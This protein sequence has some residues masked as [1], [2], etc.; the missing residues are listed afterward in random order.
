MTAIRRSPELARCLRSTGTLALAACRR[1]PTGATAVL[2]SEVCGAPSRARQID[3]QE[4]FYTVRVR[5]V[6]K[7]P[8]RTSAKPRAGGDSTVPGKSAKPRTGADST[9]PGKPQT[10]VGADPPYGKACKTTRRRRLHGT[11]KVA[12]SPKK[13]AAARAKAVTRPKP[14]TK[15]KA[16]AKPRAAVKR[17]RPASGG[18][19]QP[20]SAPAAGP[21]DI[22]MVASEMHPFASSGGLAD[23]V[24][25][26]QSTLG[27]LGHTV[28]VIVPRYRRVQVSPGIAVDN[29]TPH[30]SQPDP[31]ATATFEMGER[32]QTVS[33]YRRALT[34]QLT[35]VFVDVPE[36]FDRDGLYGDDQGDYPD[37]A[38]RFAAFSR[39]ALEYIRLRGRAPV[40]HPRA[41]L[42]G[43]AGAGLPEDA[44]LARPGRRRRSGR[45]HDSQPGVS[46]RLFRRHA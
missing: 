3:G 2:D 22:V 14:E 36:L 8:S 29:P 30:R 5:P 1:G 41:R 21:L 44:V 37:N 17:S 6:S 23:V 15:A 11:G 32:D 18:P 7:A 43:G 31:D 38:V 9:G 35:A 34:D 46:G 13:P 16:P 25:A 19:S 26:L 39:A 40:G 28:T 45:L 42:A 4:A 10:A 27:R 20:A 12:A 33:F 24:S